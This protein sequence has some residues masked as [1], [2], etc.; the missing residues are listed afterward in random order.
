MTYLIR[1]DAIQL[2]VVHL[3]V[4]IEFVRGGEGRRG[5]RRGRG[6]VDGEGGGVRGHGWERGGLGVGRRWRDVV[7]EG[8]RRRR[9]VQM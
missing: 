9:Y 4:S 3:N 8:R 6:A 1:E 5:G 7:H 2:I